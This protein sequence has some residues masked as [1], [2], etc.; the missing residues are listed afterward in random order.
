M[1]QS[2]VV[3]YLYIILS[4]SEATFSWAICIIKYVT[5][6]MC[7]CARGVVDLKKTLSENEASEV[8][9]KIGYRNS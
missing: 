7:V 9:T 8:F 6:I 1:A 5:D 2:F 4:L 3:Q